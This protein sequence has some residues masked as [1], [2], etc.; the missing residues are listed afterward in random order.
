[1]PMIDVIPLRQT[2]ALM[3]LL[4]LSLASCALQ[5]SSRWCNRMIQWLNAC[6]LPV[7]EHH[8]LTRPNDRISFSMCST[9]AHPPQSRYRTKASWK[10]VIAP[11]ASFCS[12]KNRAVRSFAKAVRNMKF[13][14]CDVEIAVTK[15]RNALAFL[16][17]R[18]ASSASK[19]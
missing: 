10:Y 17:D 11:L 1:M 5:A 2:P 18:A 14:C 7:N 13:P 3:K 4:D 9:F 8:Y 12:S 6:E 16:P 19:R 15:R